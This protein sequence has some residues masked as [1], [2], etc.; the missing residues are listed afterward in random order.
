MI[1][2]KILSQR[3]SA[4]PH[5]LRIRFARASDR[6]LIRRF[7]ERLAA[8]GVTYR[9]PLDPRLPGEHHAPSGY[10]VNRRL[11]LAT[12]NREMRGGVLLQNH[13][14]SIWGQ[15]QPFCWLQLPLSESLVNSDYART[16]IPLLHQAAEHQEFAAVLGVGS[17]QEKLAKILVKSSWDHRPVPLFFYPVNLS[18][19]ALKLRY[20]RSRP[21]LNLGARAAAYSGVASAAGVIRGITRAVQ[22]TR[23]SVTSIRVPDFDTW[24]DEVYQRCAPQYGVLANRDAMT[25]RVLYPP[26]DR[27]YIR[28]RVLSKATGKDLGWIMVVHRKMKDDKYFGNLHVGTL[29]NGCCELRHVE[30]VIAAGFRELIDLGVDLVVCNWSHDTWRAATSA[31]G[32]LTGPSNFFFFTSPYGTPIVRAAGPLGAMHLTRGD[33]DT[34][35]SLMPPFRPDSELS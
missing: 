20:L 9:M 17:M 23:A 16:F 13:R 18:A 29:V 21:A 3:T 12:Q 14:V 31:L 7:N 33:G 30:S 35:A 22:L 19:V 2:S 4:E 24:A 10:F 26:E 27:R 6:D 34:P 28:L 25:L 11:L 15:E 32:F 8:G 5:D 1:S